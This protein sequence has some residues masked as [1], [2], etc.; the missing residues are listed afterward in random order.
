M[1]TIVSKVDEY[2]F[3]RPDDFDY[4]AYES[5][6]SEYLRVLARR[7]AKW[8]KFVDPDQKVKKSFKVKRYCRKGVPSSQRAQV[9]FDISGARKRLKHGEG[10]FKRM[11]DSPKELQVTDSIKTDLHRTFPDNVYFTNDINSK[12]DSLFNVLSAYAHY[13]PTVGYCQGFNYIVG[14]LLLVV[15]EE[16]SAFWL[17]D[18]LI[19]KKLPD[20]YGAKMQG[21]RV[22][23]G[24][25]E[26]LL[27][28]KLPQLAQHMKTVDCAIAIPTTKWLVC[29][30]IDVLPTETV[31]RIWDCLFYEGSKILLR[32]AL[33]LLSINEQTLLACRDFPSLCQGFKDITKSVET[34]D[35][36]HF[37]KECFTKP[38]SLARRKITRL[39]NKKQE[40]LKDTS[41]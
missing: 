12:K 6:M 15:K 16:E 2:G 30:Y 38:G 32:V 40:K 5:F 7:A 10:V 22:E 27:W 29:L 25:L 4:G 8:E 26:D 37:M 19:T 36:H 33:T 21:L 28:W 34:I 14:L 39:R 24:V 18:V 9:W 31:L 20:Y 3:E 11:L 35:C 17:L 23:Q 1:S 13:N 41:S